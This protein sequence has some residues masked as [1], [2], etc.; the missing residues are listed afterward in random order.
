M[1]SG[2]CEWLV[3]AVES[4]DGGERGAK[5]EAGTGVVHLEMRESLAWGLAIG[6]GTSNQS[7]ALTLLDP[8]KKSTRKY[9]V[10]DL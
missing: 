10:A 6:K 5:W 3:A 8:Q 4:V 2:N 9:S 1:A 7:R